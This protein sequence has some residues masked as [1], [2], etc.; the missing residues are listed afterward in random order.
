M[1]T[2]IENIRARTEKSLKSMERDINSLFV[3]IEGR[4]QLIDALARV[5]EALTEQRTSLLQEIG[6]LR[7]EKDDEAK[8]ARTN[9]GAPQ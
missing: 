1:G 4:G 2:Q 7:E 6:S 8:D 5:R 9:T 3:I